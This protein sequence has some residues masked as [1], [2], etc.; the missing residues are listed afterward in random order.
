[1]LKLKSS[2][3]TVST[4]GALVG[5]G[6]DSAQAAVNTPTAA[7]ITT[8]AV[9]APAKATKT[10]P[11]LTISGRG[12]G[13]GRG[14][15]QWG[16]YGAAAGP[17][18]LTW[19]QILAFYY[20]GTVAA[21]QSNAGL[22]VRLDAVGKGASTVAAST[23]LTVTSGSVAGKTCRLV[24]PTS[25]SIT[26]W[27][28]RRTSPV[29]VGLEY[30]SASTRSWRT[31]SPN[32]S[33]SC[34]AVPKTAEWTFAT[35]TSMSSSVVRVVLPSG[36]LRSYRGWVRA[37]PDVSSSTAQMTI[38]VVALE[39]YL[40]SVVPSEM[41]ASWATE[42]VRAQ[43]VAARTYA[44]RRLRS[45]SSYDICDTTACQVYS[46]VAR[47]VAASDAAI[48]ATR[49]VVLRYGSSLAL[50]EFSAYNGGWTTSSTVPYQVA[51]A[52]PYDSVFPTPAATWKVTVPVSEVVARY[53]QLGALT[54][55]QVLT[56]NGRG[57]F[58]GRVGDLMLI[59]SKSSVRTTGPSFAGIF[60][61]RSSWF[62]VVMPA[63]NSVSW[64]HDLTGDGIADLIGREAYSQSLYL[65]SGN[66]SGALNARR[67]VGSGNGLS[68][69]MISP[70]FS[71]D[72]KAD[73][74]AR[75]DSSG[76]LVM[77][78]GTGNGEFGARV[79]IGSGWGTYGEL[80]AVDWDGDGFADVV[81]RASSGL[82]FLYRGN[83]R[84]GW[85]GR[86]QIGSGWT[87]YSRLTG[88]GDF[89]GDG[90]PDVL[91]VENRTGT[92]WRYRGNGSG[93]FAGR[94]AVSTGWDGIDVVAS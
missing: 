67:L 46:G 54:Q 7:R 9:T 70:D 83:G 92:L 47:E 27:R 28:V 16:A 58:G 20:P 3:L 62:D 37:V 91:A 56:R 75:E 90:K 79:Q 81:A 13:H 40:R 49:S 24:L 55:I 11:M 17:A 94:V 8:A 39:D 85:L 52:D 64:N 10:E 2:F 86:V 33:S 59:G 57:A 21:S 26:S 14:M 31:W 48:A 12:Y 4:L 29:A 84:G 30:Y 5:F 74:L 68:Q 42:A 77:M 38:N 43:A 93:S 63:R 53:P 36:S 32:V 18:R 76:A 87:E 65:Y 51:K 69:V 88:P 89:D 50:T 72:G 41:P 82:L 23:G 34:T 15:S 78:K 60:G 1:M 66:G 80:T 45:S 35:S 25:S 61:L 19:R 44:A 73:L 6:A 71:G 22:R